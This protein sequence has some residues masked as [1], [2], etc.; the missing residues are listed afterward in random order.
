MDDKA[1][2]MCGRVQTGLNQLRYRRTA[3]DVVGLDPDRSTQGASRRNTGSRSVYDQ[4]Y[5]M[6]LRP[7][8]IE[9]GSKRFAL[10]KFDYVAGD[11]ALCDRHIGE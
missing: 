9:W 3:A 1:E 8:S 2:V 5:A 4:A 6:M 10:E 11:L 7:G